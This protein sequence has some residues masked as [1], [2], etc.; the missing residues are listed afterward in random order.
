MQV[1]NSHCLDSKA[2]LLVI[3]QKCENHSI[4]NFENFTIHDTLLLQFDFLGMDF[5]LYFNIAILHER[6]YAAI[7]DFEKGNHG[8]ISSIEWCIVHF[9]LIGITPCFIFVIIILI[10]SR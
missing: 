6:V 2:W 8:P 9:L 4:T 5:I 7:G 1:T 10:G 3:D